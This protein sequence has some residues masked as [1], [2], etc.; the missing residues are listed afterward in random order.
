MNV[1]STENIKVPQMVHHTIYPS[2][3]SDRR[4][5]MVSHTD[6]FFRVALEVGTLRYSSYTPPERFRPLP[7]VASLDHVRNWPSGFSIIVVDYIPKQF[8][9]NVVARLLLKYILKRLW[10][11]PPSIIFFSF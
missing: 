8:I 5:H 2:R 11:K 6:A 7:L 9:A 3:R 10:I 4:N 1:E